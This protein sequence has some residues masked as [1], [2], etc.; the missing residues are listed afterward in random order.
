MPG[1]PI[2]PTIPLHDDGAHHGFLRLPYSRDDSAWGSVMIPITVIKNGVGPT[3]LL[4]GANHGDEY[5][6]PIALMEL[7][8]TLKPED[9]EGRVIIVPAMKLSGVPGRHPAPRRSTGANMNR[10]FPGSPSGTVTEKIADYF[11][12]VLLPEA[13]I[14]LDFHSGGKTLDFIPFASAHVLEKQGTAGGLCRRGGS[15]QRA[16]LDDHARDR[17][18]RHV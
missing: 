9:I 5:E 10:S 14:V 7:A 16:L 15:L 2:V 18:C 6:G 3:A 1:N 11:Q 17:H 12:T 13:S 4:T 8:V